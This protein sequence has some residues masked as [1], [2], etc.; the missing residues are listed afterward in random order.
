MSWMKARSLF[1]DDFGEMVRGPG[2]GCC[3]IWWGSA[4]CKLDN[5]NTIHGSGGRV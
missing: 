1:S 4:E 2:V 3:M 5:R